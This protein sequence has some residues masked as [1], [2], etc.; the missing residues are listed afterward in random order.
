MEQCLSS[1]GPSCRPKM[2]M[3]GSE[4]QD[5]GSC[6]A[7]RF[8]NGSPH[9]QALV[10]SCRCYDEINLE[11]PS[12][13]VFRHIKILFSGSQFVSDIVL[14]KKGRVKNY[15][16]HLPPPSLKKIPNLWI[17]KYCLLL[18]WDWT[19]CW[20]LQVST[21]SVLVWQCWTTSGCH[22]GCDFTNILLIRTHFKPR[23]NVSPF[24]R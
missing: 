18:H 22:R 3:S 9:F 2:V 16:L 23:C 14:S 13:H 4:N 21:M 17:C 1:P 12:R 24:M 15:K 8:Q 5:G 20:M 6:N 11:F 19:V 7:S 10:S